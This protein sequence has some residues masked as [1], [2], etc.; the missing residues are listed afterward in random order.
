MTSFIN[1]T[2]LKTSTR[3]AI[4]RRFGVKVDWH[5][6]S[7][8]RRYVLSIPGAMTGGTLVADIEAAIRA[9]M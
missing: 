8:K 5:T 3:N 2:D 1:V 4:A 7:G 6:V 9:A